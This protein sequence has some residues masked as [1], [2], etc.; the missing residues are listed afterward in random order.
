MTEILCSGTDHNPA[1][2]APVLGTAEEGTD[3]A[4]WGYLC[5]SCA[6]V[7]LSRVA[8][9]PSRRPRTHLHL[10]PPPSHPQ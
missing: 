6:T 9:T 3:R 8:A 10:L 2:P 5:E 7:W 1:N 4:A